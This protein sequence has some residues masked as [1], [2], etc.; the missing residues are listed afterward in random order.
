MHPSRPHA[1]AAANAWARGLDV[2]AANAPTCL[3]KRRQWVAWKYVERDGKP[4]K[5]PVNPGT[6]ALADSTDAATWGTFEQ[7]V[8]ACRQDAGLAG[9]G[10]VFSAD[11][12]F[13][14]VDLDDCLE[15]DTGQ[16]KPWARQIVDRLASYAE[17]SPSGT[18]VKI[19]TILKTLRELLRFLWK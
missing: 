15:A 11:D 6:G 12:P 13:S 14:G 9:V 16:L 4:T 5:C 17:I 19:S 1:N 2:T 7:A 10:F 18:G 8:A 3:R